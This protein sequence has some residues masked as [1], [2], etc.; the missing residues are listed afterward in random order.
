MASDWLRRPGFVYL[1]YDVQG[2]L[3]YVGSTIHVGRRLMEHEENAPWWPQ[4]A[5][6]D[7][8]GPFDWRV[9]AYER[10]TELIRDRKPLY[11]QRPGPPPGT[12]RARLRRQLTAMDEQHPQDEEIIRLR[13]A[14]KTRGEIMAALGISEKSL[15][16]I[17]KRL[18]ATG[19]VSRVPGSARY[20]SSA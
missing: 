19:R 16:K 18:L 12:V 20:H 4:V 8:E 11:N 13:Q 10:E 14:G 15:A 7:I 3:L 9:P 1:A 5:R 17:V 6:I 2:R